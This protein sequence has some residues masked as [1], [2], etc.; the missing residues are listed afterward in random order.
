MEE[1][2]RSIGDAIAIGAPLYNRNTNEGYEAC[3]R[4]YEGTALKY[5]KDA[6]CK[7]VRTAFGD[8][9]LRAQSMASFKEKAWALRD[10]FDGL[11]DAFKRWCE[12]D[13]ACMKKF[14]PPS[15]PSAPTGAGDADK[16]KK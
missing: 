9:L 8:G 12:Q 7:G 2:L 14:G 13:K 1:V 11:I 3:F 16:T 15:G 4:V 5:E 6:P 10:T